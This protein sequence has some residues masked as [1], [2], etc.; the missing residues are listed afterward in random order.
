VGKKTRFAAIGEKEECRD[1]GE[2]GAFRVRTVETK[3]WGRVEGGGA[4]QKDTMVQKSREGV[5]GTRGKEGRG[6]F[7]KL[8][9]LGEGTV[10]R[11][12]RYPDREW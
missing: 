8:L 9:K 1:G 12:S 6:V 11:L 5:L 10:L 3:K 2:G 4:P 7:K